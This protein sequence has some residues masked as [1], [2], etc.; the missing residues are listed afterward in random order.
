M[1]ESKEDDNVILP[2]PE[3]NVISSSFAENNHSKTSEK[4]DDIAALENKQFKSV[5]DKQKGI[6]EELEGKNT[7][8]EGCDNGKNYRA[9]FKASVVIIDRLHLRK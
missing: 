4:L 1:T 9:L 5:A 6:K 8:H 3:D 2:Q 7:Q